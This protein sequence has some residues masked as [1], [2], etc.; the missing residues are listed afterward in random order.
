MTDSQKHAQKRDER[1]EVFTDGGANPNPG[2]GGWAAVIRDPTTERVRELAGGEPD[3]TNNRMELTAAIRALESLDEAVAVDLFTDST[4]LRQGITKWLPGWIRRNWQRFDSRGQAHPVKNVDL[5]QRLGD[6]DARRQIRWHWVRGHAGHLHNERADELATSEIAK[7]KSTSSRAGTL[8]TASNCEGRSERL[9]EPS[10][11]EAVIRVVCRGD[12]G[13]WAAGLT[14]GGEA[15]SMTGQSASTTAN[16]LEL[17]A[18][19]AVLRKVPKGRRLA[20][21]SGDYLRR[22][23]SE[24]LAD[25]K[26]RGF[27]TSSGAPVKNPDLWRQLDAD[28]QGRAVA[29]L[30]LAGDRALERELTRLALRLLAP[31]EDGE[32]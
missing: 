32:R 7:L 24:W 13:A 22:G 20:V 23:A 1:R 14:E 21:R 11:I 6:L 30:P 29:F 10:D 19:L 17:E 2:P 15:T 4:Y 5:W 3:T 27:R 25:W 18:A 31:A 9:T 12:R 26:R 28:C 8:V 16:R